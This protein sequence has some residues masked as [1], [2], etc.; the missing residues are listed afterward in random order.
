[1][2]PKTKAKAKAADARLLNALCIS[3]PASASG[4]TVVLPSIWMLDAALKAEAD[5]A[6]AVSTYGGGFASPMTTIAAAPVS[7]TMMDL[8]GDYSDDEFI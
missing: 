6:A 5:K 7:T 1:M 2:A 3:Y 4:E 8:F